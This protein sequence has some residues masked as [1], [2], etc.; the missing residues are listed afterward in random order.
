MFKLRVQNVAFW[1]IAPT[2]FTRYCYNQSI[3][4]RIDNL[5]RIHKNREEKGL[6]GTAEK[7]GIYLNHGGDQ[8]FDILNGLH[9]R[10][11]SLVH[12]ITSRPYLDNPFVRF[13][14]NI[15]QYPSMQHDIDDTIMYETDNFER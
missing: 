9:V 6:G 8:G 2:L 14:E 13:H 10:F 15:E 7:C 4:D 11:D 12:G 5:W 3:D 1:A